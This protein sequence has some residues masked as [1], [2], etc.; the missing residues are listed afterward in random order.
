MANLYL[1]LLDRIWERHGLQNR[2]GTRIVRYADDIVLLCRKNGSAAAMDVLRRILG[3][4]ELSLNE[5]K[6]KIVN[7]FDEEFGFLG[8][9]IKMGKGLRTGRW[10]PH[11]EPSKKSS[12]KIKDRITELTRRGRTNMPMEW[13]VKEVNA[14]VRGW[15]GYFHY[16]NCSKPLGRIRNHLEQ[17]MITHLRKRHKVRDRGQGYVRFPSRSLY[18]QYGLYKVPTTA[19]WTKRMPCDE[20]HRK[21][22]CGRT[23]RTV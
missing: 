9:S 11:V 19:G 5:R 7:A 13:V 8:F 17:R 10:Y 22:V 23:A 3:K 1:H 2:L 18:E 20:E 21:A 16:R 6:T 4:L 15:V 14:T 12:Q